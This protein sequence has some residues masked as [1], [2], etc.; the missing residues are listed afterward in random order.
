MENTSYSTQVV[1]KA[2]TWAYRELGVSQ[3]EAAKL[4]AATEDSSG[5]AASSGAQYNGAYYHRQLSFIRMYHLL[6]V[7]SE[8]DSSAMKSLYQR[9]HSAIGTSPKHLCFSLN[10]IDK[11]ADYLRGLNDTSK[12]ATSRVETPT[13]S[14]TMMSST[15]LH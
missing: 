14:G 4:L 3:A 10:G 7:L 6:I 8:G 9:H 13:S 5:D 2:F 12:H 11:V 15:V 1:E